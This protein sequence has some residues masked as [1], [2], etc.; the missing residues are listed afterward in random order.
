M[1]NSIPETIARE[2]N[3]SREEMDAFQKMTSKMGLVDNILRTSQLHRRD[4][5]LYFKATGS[6]GVALTVLY[7]GRMIARQGQVFDPDL[8]QSMLERTA[9]LWDSWW[10]K[11]DEIVDPKPLVN[12]DEIIQ[13]FDLQ[14]GPLV[15]KYLEQLKEEQAAGKISTREAA[16]DLLVKLEGKLH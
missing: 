5:Y 14:P 2:M 10:N 4:A 11:Y 15:G 6:S 12:G 7:L 9:F 1:P 13:R 8:M 3:L 16:F